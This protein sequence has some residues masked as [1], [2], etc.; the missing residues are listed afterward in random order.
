[1]ASGLEVSDTWHPTLRLCGH[2]QITIVGKR[3]NSAGVPWA[4]IK[5]WFHLPALGIKRMQPGSVL[6][7]ELLTHKIRRTVECTRC[8]LN[9]LRWCTSPLRSL[10]THQCKQSPQGN[11]WHFKNKDNLPRELFTPLTALLPRGREAG[12]APA[13]TGSRAA[14]AWA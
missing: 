3:A 7:L 5:P 4:K 8:P 14:G 2:S 11:E 9:R 6:S 12:L 10:T 1:M 13:Y